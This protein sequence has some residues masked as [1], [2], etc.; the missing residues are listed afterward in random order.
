MVSGRHAFTRFRDARRGAVA[1]LFALMAVPLILAAG[2]AT[3]YAR[4]GLLANALQSVADQSALAGAS[5][6]NQANGQA[7]AVAVAQNYFAKGISDLS[8]DGSIGTPTI[9]VPSAVTVKVSVTA[10][11]KTSLM[12]LAFNSVPVVVTATAQGPG[13]A[14]QFNK[15]GGFSAS[16]SDSNSIYFFV[17]PANSLPP[18]T[19]AMT[20]LFTN[21]KKVD[22]NYQTDDA[23]PRNIAVN[24]GDQVGFALVNVTGGL[25]PYSSNAYGAAT[26]TTHIFY[27]NA[28]VLSQASYPSQG[29]YYIGKTTSIFGLSFC[30]KTALTATEATFVPVA[31]VNSKV[32]STSYAHPCATRSGTTTYQNNLLINGACS[33]PAT[34]T[35]TC[36]QLYNNP[37]TLNWNDMGGGSD[38]YDYNDAV[39]TV[40]CLPNTTGS[41][42]SGQ[43]GAVILTQ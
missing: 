1:V 3:D 29:T 15:T 26:G 22:P 10:T 7:E 43:P 2:A 39:Y 4:L 18:T 11:L 14:L 28:S 9:S 30:N 12:A 41:G 42:A 27:S 38:D 25:S 16:A 23:K 24:A 40:S 31:S 37:I 32:C 8:A 36:L 20:L 17:I 19:S 21:D 5:V 35:Q 33:S 6:L 34:A 13:Y